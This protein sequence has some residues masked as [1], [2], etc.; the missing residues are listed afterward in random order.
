MSLPVCVYACAPPQVLSA[1]DFYHRPHSHPCLDSHVKVVLRDVKCANLLIGAGG[2]IKVSDY[3]LC[4]PYDYSDPA[5]I[6]TTPAGTDTHKAPEVL[7][8]RPLHSGARSM[9]MTGFLTG[10]FKNPTPKVLEVLRP[11]RAALKCGQ[12]EDRAFAGRFKK[13]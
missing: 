4:R 10:R 3:G 5:D 13:N 2:G 12:D 8:L 11:L 6:P 7:E 9:M 1:L